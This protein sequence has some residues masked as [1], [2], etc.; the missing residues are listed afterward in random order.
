MDD[1]QALARITKQLAEKL[2]PVVG[3]AHGIVVHMNPFLLAHILTSM[4]KEESVRN[5]GSG[6]QNYLIYLKFSIV[7]LSITSFFSFCSDFT[8]SLQLELTSYISN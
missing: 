4:Y 6:S 7:I 2:R 5:V 8:T 1:L 3:A